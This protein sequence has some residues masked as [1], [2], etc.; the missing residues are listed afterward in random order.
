[1]LY[2]KRVQYNHAMTSS[3]RDA[4]TRGALAPYLKAPVWATEAATAPD[5]DVALSAR[6]RLARN[7][8]D[9]PFPQQASER[10][11]RRV[12]QEVRRAALADNER[13]ADLAQVTV[14][15]LTARDRADLVDARRISPELAS[16]GANRYALLDE[17]GYLSIFIN[18]EDHIRIQALAAGNAMGAALRSAEDVDDRLVRRLTYARDARWGFLTASLTNMGAGMRVSVLTHLPALAFLGRLLDT[19]QAAHTLDISIRGAHGEGTQAAGHLFQVSNAF[20]FGLPSAHIAGRV[21]PVVD[22]LIAAERAARREIAELHTAR[23]VQNARDAWTRI[24]RADRLDAAE[25][26]T[27]LS[28]LRLSAAAKLPALGGHAPAPDAALFASLVADLHT[29]SR[30]TYP[31]AVPS[32]RDAIQRPAKIRNALRHF[33]RIR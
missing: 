12:A 4:A 13:L 6:A 10:D 21:R 30:L 23:I 14:S 8:A 22:Y 26:L 3:D 17:A 7:L 16:A 11:L 31:D 20:T 25:A 28:T 18:E 27:L 29:G 9:F 2:K 19:L 5:S 33:Y 15:S 1:M 24:E 32:V